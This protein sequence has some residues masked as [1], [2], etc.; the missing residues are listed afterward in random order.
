MKIT[1]KSKSTV[2][3]RPSMN[4]QTLTLPTSSPT[5]SYSVRSWINAS[6]E[7]NQING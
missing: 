7:E 3:V 4:A 6:V 2:G 5:I 1:S